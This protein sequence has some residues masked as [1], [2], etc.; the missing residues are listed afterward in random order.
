MVCYYQEKGAI[1][2]Q[3]LLIADSSDI[4]MSA[5]TAALKDQFQITT[6]ANGNT[7]ME[8][9]PQSQPDVL[10]LN[11]MLPYTDGIT[12]LQQT[13]YH[14]PVILAIANHMSAY[15][16]RSVTEL[17]IDYTM[18]TPS[19]SSVVA[20]LQDLISGYT[21]A[22]ST[23]DI[24][25]KALHYLHLLGFPTHLDGYRQLCVA[26]PMFVENPQQ[27]MTKELYP[28]VAQL[29]GAKDKRAVEHS[30]RKAIRTAWE[31]RDN[32][33]WRKFFTICSSGTLPCPTNKE[34]I[35]RLAEALRA[36]ESL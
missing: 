16:E 15:V 24:Q 20:R 25:A 2:V 34:F 21:S 3:K 28:A 1:T 26:L 12:A 5:L 8:L 22:D 32:A 11:L 7:L 19:V 33:V 17:G 27:L 30:I 36:P 18:I 6:C 4:F 31:H 23:M 10:V 9:L 29:C 14:P 35:C 13:T